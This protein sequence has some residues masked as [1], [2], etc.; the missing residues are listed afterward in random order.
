ME[1]DP[2]HFTQ[3]GGAR[4]GL[5]FWLAI[6][7]TTPLATI[8]VGPHEIT[9]AIGILRLKR[10]YRLPKETITRISPYNGLFSKG[11]H[12]EHLKPNAPRFVL[13]WYS[14]LDQ[15][16]AVFMRNGYPYEGDAGTKYETHA[17]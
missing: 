8:D 3:V 10:E 17:R 7:V 15:L 9:L 12:I 2:N 11:I 5:S 16:R 6:N 14:D 4:V 13:F 1:N